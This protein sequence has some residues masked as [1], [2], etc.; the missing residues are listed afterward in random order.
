MVKVIALDTYKKIGV[1]DKELNK[2]LEPGTEFEV[3]EERFN[4]LS[5]NNPFKVAFVKKA[6]FVEVKKEEPKVEEAV[7]EEEP[8]PKKRGRKKKE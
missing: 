4:V 6:P 2:I 3:S 8:K 7:V 5:G 1:K